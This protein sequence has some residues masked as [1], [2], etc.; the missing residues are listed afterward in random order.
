MLWRD[1]VLAG[2]QELRSP[3]TFKV[4]PPAPWLRT[5]RMARAQLLS[6]CVLAG[7]SGV[8]AAQVQPDAQ[9]AFSRLAWSTDSTEPRRFLSV[10]G[11]RSAVFGYSENGLEV[12]AYPVQILTS[13]SVGFRQ[14]GAGSDVAGCDR[15]P[16]NRV[17][18]RCLRLSAFRGDSSIHG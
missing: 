14:R 9:P 10:H 5:L 4:P 16:G 8:L 13:F 6:L 3:F 11:R 12:W 15:S 17:E 1:A 18:F 7:C 2:S